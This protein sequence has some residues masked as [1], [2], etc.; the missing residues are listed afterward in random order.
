MAVPQ[1]K[2]QPASLRSSMCPCQFA[3]WNH[4]MRQTRAAHLQSYN[5]PPPSVRGRWARTVHVSCR[6]VSLYHGGLSGWYFCFFHGKEESSSAENRRDS[7]ASTKK[8]GTGDRRA[9]RRCRPIY[10]IIMDVF[11]QTR[12]GKS[13]HWGDDS[14]PLRVRQAP[15]G[16]GT[17]ATQLLGNT[18]NGMRVLCA[19][20]GEHGY[21]QMD[22]EQ[23]RDNVPSCEAGA[24]GSAAL[25][26][27]LTMTDGANTD[28][29]L[30]GWVA[31]EG[32]LRDG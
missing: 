16:A 14:G 22:R 1:T 18:T 12:A 11:A 5:T 3:L 9:P 10:A 6:R 20:P 30:C 19:Y 15:G 29:R 2:R 7:S 4:K 23:S 25:R 21:R 24:P 27:G 26:R 17:C 31:W 13:G 28:T 32:A 8:K